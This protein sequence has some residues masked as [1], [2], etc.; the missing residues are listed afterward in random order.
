MEP[1]GRRLLDSLRALR[2]DGRTLIGLSLRPPVGDAARRARLSAADAAQLDELAQIADALV[3]E[4]DA[5]IVFL[6]MH[7]EQD[8]RLA[9][10]LLQRMDLRDFVTVIPGH[11]SPGTIKG[12]IANLDLVV[13]T[14]LH[15]LIFAASHSIPLIALA[16]DAKVS[17]YMASLGL[18][19]LALEQSDW[20]ASNIRGRSREV[21]EAAPRIV[22]ELSQALPPRMVAA[23]RSIDEICALA[24]SQC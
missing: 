10:L 19:D 16:Y 22:A 3:E 8:D 15:S 12:I 4:H 13:G 14:R 1:E 6:S 2:K 5:E 11:L 21:L 23:R 20:T 7:P 18:G 9:E 17:A 24:H